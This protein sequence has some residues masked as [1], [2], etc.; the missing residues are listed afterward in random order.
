MRGELSGDDEGPGEQHVGR[1]GL[2]ARKV[3]DREKL[4]EIPNYCRARVLARPSN[5]NIVREPASLPQQAHRVHHHRIRLPMAAIRF[6]RPR[7]LV[8]NSASQTTICAE[9]AHWCQ[10]SGIGH[11]Q[12][13]HCPATGDEPSTRLTQHAGLRRSLLVNEQL[14][15]G[16]VGSDGLVHKPGICVSHLEQ[17]I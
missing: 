17:T 1:S 6:R 16:V 10:W 13:P 15:T 7:P 12:S 5:E 9:V 11:D 8:P 3:H 2:G 4:I 14:A